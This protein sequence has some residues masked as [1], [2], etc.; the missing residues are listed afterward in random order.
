MRRQRMERV[1]FAHRAW[2]LSVRLSPQCFEPDLPTATLPTGRQL[3]LRIPLRGCHRSAA[4]GP[5]ARRKGGSSPQSDLSTS[6]RSG[7]TSTVSTRGRWREGRARRHGGARGAL[8]GDPSSRHARRPARTDAKA[9]KDTSVHREG[10]SDGRSCSAASS[11]A[12]VVAPP[13]PAHS[14]ASAS[15]CAATI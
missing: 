5:P 14:A 3:P 12:A 15:S 6:S 9:S 8:K 7:S 4:G 2:H 11:R 1:Q 13:R 10:L